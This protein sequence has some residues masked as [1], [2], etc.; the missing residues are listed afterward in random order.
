MEEK[1]S[2]RRVQKGDSKRTSVPSRILPSFFDFPSVP[3]GELVRLQSGFRLVFTGLGT[4]VR[5]EKTRLK[6]LSEPRQRYQRCPNVTVALFGTFGTVVEK[7]SA[8]EF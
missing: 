6:R 4:L 1:F 8:T 3:K 7:K 2:P 5:L